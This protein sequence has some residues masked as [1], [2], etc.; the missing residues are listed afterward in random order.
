MS[1]GFECKNVLFKEKIMFICHQ[2]MPNHGVLMKNNVYTY[3][4]PVL[5]LIIAQLF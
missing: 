2:I 3:G 1:A 4:A 5:H